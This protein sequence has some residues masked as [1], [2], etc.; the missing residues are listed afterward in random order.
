MFGITETTVHV[1]TRTVTPAD[2]AS[3][4]RS[5]GTALPGWSVS[6]RDDRGRP[7]PFGASGEIWVGGAGVAGG[8]LNRG[9]LTRERFRLDEHTGGTIYRSGDRGRLRPDGQLEHL[10]R[11]DNQVQLRGHR[12]ELDEIRAVLLEQPNV[13]AAAVVIAGGPDDA[14]ASARLDAYV[15]LNSGSAAGVR[16]RA[17]RMLPEYMLPGTVTA[18]PELPLT[19]NGKLDIAALPRPAGDETPAPAVAGAEPDGL[20]GTM[21]GIWG[22]VFGR[23]VSIEDDFFELGG[24][25]LLA[26]RLFAAQRNAG[27][28]RV[29]LRELYLRP[30][31]TR[32][33]DAM[34]QAPSEAEA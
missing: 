22:S 24:N 21:L 13:T 11:L 18:V 9:E 3:R 33:A 31:I 7:L 29:S 16:R 2:M 32:L 1:T 6:V 15:V 12:V 26:V 10:G 4:S 20:T 23:A 14:P 34:A 8:Y 25:S 30:T 17:A 19:L 27:L 28:P 5:V